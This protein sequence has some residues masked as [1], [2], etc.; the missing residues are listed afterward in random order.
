LLLW[1]STGDIGFDKV[2]QI[3]TKEALKT[4]EQLQAI[5]PDYDWTKTTALTL[6]PAIELANQG[7]NVLVMAYGKDRENKSQ[8]VIINGNGEK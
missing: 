8:D 7:K 3:P 5:N 1:A 4:R 6:N 2:V